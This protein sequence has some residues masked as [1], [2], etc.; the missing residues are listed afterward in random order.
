MLFSSDLSLPLVS[1]ACSRS[2]GSTRLDRELRKV[3]D[4]VREL[5]EERSEVV[6]F[7]I[8]EL[9]DELIDL[10]VVASNLSVMHFSVDPMIS[11]SSESS[12]EFKSRA[13]ILASL[14]F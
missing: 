7:G 1:L 13:F 3:K 11:S 6:E 8:I 14:N 10:V 12:V 4:D 2:S 5:N 9:D